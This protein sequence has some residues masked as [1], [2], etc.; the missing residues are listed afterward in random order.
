MRARD[1]EIQN[2][3]NAFFVGGERARNRSV[4]AFRIRD[5]LAGRG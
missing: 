1:D 5:L 2:R 4:N 3:R